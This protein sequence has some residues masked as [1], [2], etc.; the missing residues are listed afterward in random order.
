MKIFPFEVDATSDL[1]LWVQLRKRITHLINDGFYEPGE[2]LPTV[3]GLAAELAI[4]YNTVN[5]AYLSMINEGYIT[6]MRGRGVFVRELEAEQ[7]KEST[8]EALMLIN[9]CIDACT[10]LGLSSNEIRLLMT[11]SLQASELDEAPSDL[12]SKDEKPLRVVQGSG[13]V[14]LDTKEGGGGA[15]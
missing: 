1:P 3:R 8:R 12:G 14:R 9:D 2:Q 5:K 10:E 15:S 11:R 7:N 4:N 13:G 6:S